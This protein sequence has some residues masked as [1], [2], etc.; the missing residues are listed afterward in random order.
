GIERRVGGERRVPE[1]ARREEA[2]AGGERRDHV[3]WPDRGRR[4]GRSGSRARR[5]RGGRRRR[6]VRGADRRTRGPA[7]AVLCRAI[8]LG[9]P[10]VLLVAP[11]LLRLL[12]RLV[13]PVVAADARDRVRRRPAHGAG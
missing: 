12:G 1:A 9:V 4:R 2:L 13:L 6:G 5:G 7:G 8:A 10:A 3:V 11:V